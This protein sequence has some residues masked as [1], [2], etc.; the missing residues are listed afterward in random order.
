MKKKFLAIMIFVSAAFATDKADYNLMQ[1]KIDV[2][3]YAINL[4]IS[5][6]SSNISAKTEIN[7]KA[8]S[9]LEELKFNLKEMNVQSCVLDSKPMNFK[10]DDGILK[11]LLTEVIEKNTN[12]TIAI[13]Y[14]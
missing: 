8:V 9:N 4:K 1:Y 10:N 2:I 5:D 3:H 13:N 14:N 6:L 7:F 12:H 11:I